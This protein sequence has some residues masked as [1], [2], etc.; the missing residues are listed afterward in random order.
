MT[1]QENAV[2]EVMRWK[3]ALLAELQKQIAGKDLVYQELDHHN[4]EYHE[5]FPDSVYLIAV[6]HP[7]KSGELDYRSIIIGSAIEEADVKSNPNRFGPH[8]ISSEVVEYSKKFVNSFRC[9]YPHHILYAP[10]ANGVP[11]YKSVV[12]SAI[13]RSGNQEQSPKKDEAVERAQVSSGKGY[14]ISPIRGSGD[15]M[16][17]IGMVRL[18]KEI[19]EQIVKLIDNEENPVPA[20]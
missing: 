5:K 3:P 12:K 18:N 2:A 4:F 11:S 14:L 8:L 17:H 1:T 16:L 10:R 19:A 6:G 9:G 15:V 13:K 7:P 20:L